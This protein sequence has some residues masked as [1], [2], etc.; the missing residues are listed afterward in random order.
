M[1]QQTTS[2]NEQHEQLLHHLHE[3][4]RVHD[5][6]HIAQIHDLRIRFDAQLRETR[7]AH[8]GVQVTSSP[9]C[10]LR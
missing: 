5:A 9:R 3:E 6:E 1:I 10:K 7:A 4:Q 2:R 8:A